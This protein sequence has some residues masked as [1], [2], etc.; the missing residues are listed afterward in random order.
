MMNRVRHPQSLDCAGVDGVNPLVCE[1]HPA[2]VG[3]VH[4]AGS[5]QQLKIAGVR[6][7]CR[8]CVVEVRQRALV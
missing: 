5:E 8:P 1:A 6:Y 2:R 3:Q 4:T 7:P